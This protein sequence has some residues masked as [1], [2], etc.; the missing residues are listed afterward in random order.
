META[1]LISMVVILTIVFG[2]FFLFL[3]KAIA[4]EQKKA[5]N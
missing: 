5:A 4:K 2:G 1:S 3:K